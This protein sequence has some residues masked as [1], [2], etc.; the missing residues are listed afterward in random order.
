MRWLLLIALV[1]CSGKAKETAQSGCDFAG[2]YRLRFEA[3]V[4]QKLWFRFDVDK[5]ARK[6]TLVK[7][8]SIGVDPANYAL[9]LDPDPASCKLDVIAKAKQGD[10]LA[11]LTLDPKTQ[12]VTGTLRIAGERS[13]V[14]I[15]GVRDV[16]ASPS[17]QACVKP[18]LYELVVPAEQ[19]WTPSIK[20]RSCETAE[21]R[22][23]FLVEFIGDKL[24]VDQLEDDGD[25]A[26]AAEDVYTVAPC[27]AEVRFRRFESMAYI[28]L[29]FAGDTVSAEATN[30]DVRMG[31]VD[32]RW[33]CVANEPMAWVERKA[34]SLAAK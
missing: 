15:S 28:R 29:G 31:E 4:G 18:G 26:W 30:V 8:I 25:A 33:R 7:P 6:A 34:D 1:G 14:P 17:P 24:V 11:S 3:G 13:G 12:V 10:I 19:G 22:V 32:D 23:P 20:D 27:Q 2:R 9:E 5:G 21:L 16:G